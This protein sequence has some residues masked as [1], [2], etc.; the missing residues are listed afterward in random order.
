LNDVIAASSPD[1]AKRMLHDYADQRWQL[2]RRYSASRKRH[3]DR[4]METVIEEQVKNGKL[5][6]KQVGLAMNLV[7]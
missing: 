4:V 6:W 1:E 3:A 2:Q 7:A 5:A